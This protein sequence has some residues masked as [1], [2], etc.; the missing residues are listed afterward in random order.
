MFDAEGLGEIAVKTL[1]E[2]YAYTPAVGL[3][4][5]IGLMV[6]CLKCGVKTF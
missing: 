4:E 1:V 5:V 6:F 2:R 3:A